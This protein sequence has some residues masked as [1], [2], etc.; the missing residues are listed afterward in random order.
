M[1][2]LFTPETKILNEASYYL[3]A[4]SIIIP[5][6]PK[7]TSKSNIALLLNSAA[8]K[9]ERALIENYPVALGKIVMN[10]LKAVYDGLNYA[11]H[12]KS[13]AI[14]ISPVFEKIIYLSISVREEISVDEHFSI[15]N[16]VCQ[17]EKNKAYNVMVLGENYCSI[18]FSK[19]DD[20]KKIFFKNSHTCFTGDVLFEPTPYEKS[21]SPTFLQQVDAAVKRI[22]LAYPAPLFVVGTNKAIAQ[23]KK[24]S[25]NNLLVNQFIPIKADSLTTI[26]LQKMVQPFT[27]NWG[28]VKNQYLLDKLKMAAQLNQLVFGIRE[29]W[30]EAMQRHGKLLLVQTNYQYCPEK[31]SSDEI[32]NNATQPFN[33]F[34]YIKDV[35]DA[36]I[37]K[38][39]ENGGDVEFVE[40]DFLK[41]LG[42][43]ALIK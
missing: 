15:R 13:L 26:E 30:Y 39:L 27:K 10:K 35:V 18:Y 8:D 21:F 3:P 5:F 9:V 11:T 22:L 24:M 37:E 38:V 34:S 28:I 12:K 25:N 32:I 33:E 40:E 16:I 6:E 19:A 42:P 23:F 17:K 7:I 2:S 31:G 41:D 1:Y 14:F 20:F 4:I 36:A 43:I 29:V